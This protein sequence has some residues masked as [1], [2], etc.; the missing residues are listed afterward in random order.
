MVIPLDSTWTLF[1]YVVVT[2]HKFTWLLLTDIWQQMLVFT[3]YTRSTRLCVSQAYGCSPLHTWC[4]VRLLCLQYSLSYTSQ[5]YSLKLCLSILDCAY[6]HNQFWKFFLSFHWHYN[7]GYPFAEVQNLLLVN[8]STEMHTECTNVAASWYLWLMLVCVMFSIWSISNIVFSFVHATLWFTE[9][10]WY[11][12]YLA[13][14]GVYILRPF[15]LH[16]FRIWSYIHAVNGFHWFLVCT[17]LL[18]RQTWRNMDSF[19]FIDKRPDKKKNTN[20]HSPYM[21][22]TL[23]ILMRAVQ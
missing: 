18:C 2:L 5:E 14:F 21:S 17:K 9:L 8:I 7:I 3:D 22:W 4:P 23:M 15:P 1:M 16:H 13:M 19:I 20:I 12:K 11:I 6:V 10:H